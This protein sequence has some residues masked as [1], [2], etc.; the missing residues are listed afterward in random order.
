[1]PT[2]VPQQMVG[3]CKGKLNPGV[4]APL[5]QSWVAAQHIPRSQNILQGFCNLAGFN[6][7]MARIVGKYHLEDVHRLHG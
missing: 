2:T 7:S 4:A 5:L 6:A 1:M 3:L